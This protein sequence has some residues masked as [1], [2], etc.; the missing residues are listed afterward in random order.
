MASMIGAAG[1]GAVGDG[2]FG[3]SGDAQLCRLVLFEVDGCHG[4]DGR[5]GERSR[6]GLDCGVKNFAGT[7]DGDGVVLGTA[8]SWLAL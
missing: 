1:D 6:L 5:E 4:K 3:D 2:A 8:E 7:G